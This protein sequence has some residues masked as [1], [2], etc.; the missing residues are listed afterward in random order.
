MKSTVSLFNSSIGSKALMALTGL[1]GYGFVIGHIAGNLLMFA[2]PN[3]INAY[4]EA[5]QNLPFGGVWIARAILTAAVV[6]HVILAIKLKKENLTARPV[7]YAKNNTKVASKA[8]LSMAWTGG[9][10][11]FFIL[12]HLAHFTWRVVAYDGPYFDYQGRF[13]IFAMVVASFEQPALAAL[14]LAGMVLVGFHLTHGS[15]SLFQT[16]GL[17]HLR[18]NRII[19]FLPP[20]IGWIVALAGMSIPLAV[21]FGIIA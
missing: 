1:I 15:Q 21:L 3:A 19:K 4:G 17:N 20:F 8:S 16:L 5:L 11:L 2:G 9:L 14:Y 18:Y 7:A 13:D 10:I 6:V 12:F